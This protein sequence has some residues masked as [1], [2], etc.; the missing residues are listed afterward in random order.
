MLAVAT[1]WTLEYIDSLPMDEFNNMLA[2]NY[3]EPYTHDVQS[4]RDGLLITE[5]FNAR[6]KK[7]ILV[8]DM[9]P[10][11]SDET[12]DWLVDK[13]IRIAKEFITRHEEGCIKRKVTPTYDYILPLIKE[14]I[15]IENA[16][17]SPD[18]SKIDGLS[19]LLGRIDNGKRD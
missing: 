6:R 12:P 14:E 3:I 8:A 4:R 1:G 9:F 11:M 10:Y 13:T 5:T 7:Q 17:K 19:K 15:A 16:K 18:K 2:L